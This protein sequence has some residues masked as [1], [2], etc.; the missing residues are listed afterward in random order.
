MQTYDM[1]NLDLSI[2]LRSVL[3]VHGYKVGKFGE[4]IHDHPI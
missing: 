1:S 2:L 3:G 4:S